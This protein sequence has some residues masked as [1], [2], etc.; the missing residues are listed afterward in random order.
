MKIN[1]PANQG[2]INYV[3][4]GIVIVFVMSIL[5][6][7]SNDLSFAVNENENKKDSQDNKKDITGTSTNKTKEIQN[8]ELKT[9]VRDNIENAHYPD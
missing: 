1:I 2:N 6:V 8:V 3:F 9:D 4:L 5:F 7:S